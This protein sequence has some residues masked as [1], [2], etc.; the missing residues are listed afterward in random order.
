MARKRYCYQCQKWVNTE[1]DRCPN[2]NSGT[3][4]VR[5][6][7]NPEEVR[8][9]IS[10]KKPHRAHEKEIIKMIAQSGA[11]LEGDFILENN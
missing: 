6:I 2:C 4:V 9:V 11:I 10:V 3:F 1:N 8:M 5:R 7:T